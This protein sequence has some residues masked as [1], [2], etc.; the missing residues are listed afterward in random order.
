MRELKKRKRNNKQGIIKSNKK[1]V[2]DTKN[3]W[4]EENFMCV[5]P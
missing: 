4:V 1:L 5:F 3:R 2:G